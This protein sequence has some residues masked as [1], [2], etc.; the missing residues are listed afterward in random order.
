MTATPPMLAVEGHYWQAALTVDAAGL[1][2]GG[3]AGVGFVVWLLWSG[4]WCDPLSG[5][6]TSGQ[7]PSVVHVG[8]IIVLYVGLLVLVG[9]LLLGGVDPAT[10]RQPGSHWWHLA[11]TADAVARLLSAA[12][13]VWML[14]QS[15]LFRAPPCRRLGPLGVIAVGVLGALIVTPILTV[16]LQMTTIAGQKLFPDWSPPPHA[17]LEALQK[18]E[19]G[20]LAGWQLFVVAAVVAPLVEE[21]FFRG[22]LLQAVWRYTHHAWLAV[23]V[24]GVAFGAV[25]SQQPQAVLPLATMGVVLGY[26]RLRTASLPACII[27]HALFNARTMLAALFFPELMNQA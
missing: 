13:M 10:P 26:V 7:G 11:Q 19:W 27:A 22:L 20:P 17:V 3:V 1:I 4:Q 2:L 14:G 24:S 5:V 23:L 8:A 12:V 9:Q 16:Q 21:L 25:H 18:T 6:E 15:R